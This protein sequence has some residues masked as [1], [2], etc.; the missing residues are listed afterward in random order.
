MI[1]GLETLYALYALDRDCSTTILGRQMAEFPV[2]PKLCIYYILL[3]AFLI[4]SLKYGCTEEALTIA[5]MISVQHIFR[6]Q[7]KSQEG[8]WKWKD[9]IHTLSVLI[10]II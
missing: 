6:D 8:G 2:E 5:S 10:I 9:S 4:A 3:A 1:R 7:P